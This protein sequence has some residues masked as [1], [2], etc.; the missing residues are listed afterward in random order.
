MKSDPRS[1]HFSELISS[2]I[3]W[4]LTNAC[5]IIAEGSFISVAPAAGL[6]PAAVNPD[7]TKPSRTVLINVVQFATKKEKRQSS[8]VFCRS[9]TKTFSPLSTHQMP[10]RV[11][12]IPA[13]K[14]KMRAAA[15]ARRPGPAEKTDRNAFS[16]V[17][18][19]PVFGVMMNY[20][21]RRA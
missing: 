7:Q 1:Y 9:P 5:V 4:V 18:K 17:V 3:G 2:A 15:G 13:I 6:E 16:K 8:K 21:L 11:N 19:I 12:S 20:R 14:N 10:A